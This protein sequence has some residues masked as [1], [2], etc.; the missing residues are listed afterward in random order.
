MRHSITRFS[1]LLTLSVLLIS[2]N[3]AAQTPPEVLKAYKAYNTAFAAQDYKTALKQGKSAWK[4][5]ESKLG[6]SKITGD[7]AFNY[8]FLAKSQGKAKEAIKPLER[9][10]DLAETDRDK[11]EEVRLERTVELIS[12]AENAGEF[13]A[14]KAY[15][16]EAL[17]FAE[18]N[19][20]SSTVFAGEILVHR[21]TECS[22]KV[23]RSAKRLIGKP[24][25]SRLSVQT[26]QRGNVARMQ[27][28]CAIDS[29]AASKIFAA[30]PKMARPK[31][32]ALAAKQ[33]GLA[34]ERDQDWLNAAL[35]Y[36]VARLAI[37]EK[38]GRDNPLA[39]QMIGRWINARSRLSFKG[40]LE[41]A[42][43]AGLCD[44]WPFDANASKV[45]AVKKVAPDMPTNAI[46]IKS[47]GV[48]V[49]EADVSESGAPQNLSV[50]YSWPEG[51]YDAAAIKAFKQYQFAPKSGAEPADA[52]KGV[53]ESFSF[54][55]YSD[56]NKETF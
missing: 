14:V 38:Y 44:C 37:E 47:S 51:E 36:Q 39:T 29:Q 54:I 31:Y 30:V 3:A 5:A 28:K 18:A 26:D 41:S 43:S 55:L 10:V 25:S 48:V 23:N 21:A 19:G 46:A 50:V 13:K 53:V 2:V 15:A 12:A 56:S 24:T 8:G 1:T 9:A 42:K 20:L 32:I 27:K 35:N 22:R 45:K 17:S 6:D 4:L 16:D 7:L 40:K 33:S 34:Y 49:L 11:G 52:R